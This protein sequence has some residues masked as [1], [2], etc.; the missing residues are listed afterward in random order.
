MGNTVYLVYMKLVTGEKRSAPWL[1]CGGN[2]LIR[3]ETKKS[4]YVAEKLLKTDLGDPPTQEN[5]QAADL[6]TRGLNLYCE[7]LPNTNVKE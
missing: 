7:L 5:T 1:V 3:R 6:G 4:Q 2:Q